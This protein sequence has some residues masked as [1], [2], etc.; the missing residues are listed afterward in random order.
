MAK[1][2]KKYNRPK[3]YKKPGPGYFA[4]GLKY[5][6]M[7]VKAYKTAMFL[8]TV[9]NPELKFF[10]NAVGSAISSTGVITLLNSIPQ[11]NDEGQRDGNS[12]K[13]NKIVV[14]ADVARN[15]SATS[16]A[17]F[18][19]YMIVC[20]TDGQ[21]STPA[22]TDILASADP[23]SLLNILTYPGRFKVLMDKHF[24]LD[25]GAQQAVTFQ[26]IID[27]N[28]FPSCNHLHYSSTTGASVKKN[29]LYLVQVGSEATNTPSQ[30]TNIRLRY[31]D[32]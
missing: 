2:G 30:D 10:D 6:S 31:Y 21:G 26:H 11:G 22:V 18:I 19:R 25:T 3:V 13:L 17:T 20:D 23:A 5:A 16:T 7:A 9:L 1:Y 28:K 8:K 4:S 24:H 15:S 14:R 32:N 12:I 27:M 29:A